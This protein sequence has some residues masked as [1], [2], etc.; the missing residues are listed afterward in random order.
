MAKR[1]G[2]SEQTITAYAARIYPTDCE[3]AVR[4][5][6]YATE[7]AEDNEDKAEEALING[8]KTEDVE[9]QVQANYLN[10]LKN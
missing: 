5:W 10:K 4:Y 2:H 1:W 3:E 8:Q 7:K 6:Y 9:D